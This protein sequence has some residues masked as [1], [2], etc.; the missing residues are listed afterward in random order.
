MDDFEK[1]LKSQPMRAVPPQWREEILSNARAAAK[2]RTAKTPATGWQAW[3]WPSPYAWGALAAMW[4]AILGFNLASNA[5]ARRNAPSGPQPTNE[6]IMAMLDERR[7]MEQ[8]V[9]AAFAPRKPSTHAP[10]EE[11]K[12]SPG[13]YLPNRNSEN[14][15]IA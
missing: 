3:L 1:L 15:N 8:Q 5:Q 13:A 10:K 12:P 7:R 2:P 6:Q 14:T 4:V 9:F 11:Q